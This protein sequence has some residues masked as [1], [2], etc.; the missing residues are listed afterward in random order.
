MPSI[1]KDDLKN[2]V[3][4]VAVLKGILV[5]IAICLL[6][7]IGTGVFY[8]VTSVSEETLLLSTVFIIAISVFSGSLAAGKGAGNKG[9]YNG[10]AVGL[11]F[12]LAVWLF[13][14]LIFPGHSMLSIIYKLLITLT[15]GAVGGIIGVGLS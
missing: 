7:S 3:N 9:L 1:K 5:A 4:F 14:G 11:F 15:A 8:H 13:S 6:L 12:F 2:P 10:L